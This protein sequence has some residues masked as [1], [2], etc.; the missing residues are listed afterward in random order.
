MTCIVIIHGPH[1]VYLR[2][3]TIIWRVCVC[4]M[5]ML[6]RRD[7]GDFGHF[8]WLS[9]NIN[10]VISQIYHQLNCLY[11][12]ANFLAE[13]DMSL[14]V[15]LSVPVKTI[16]VPL[17]FWGWL[18]IARETRSDTAR[19]TSNTVRETSDTKGYIGHGLGDLGHQRRLRA[20]T[21]T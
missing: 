10:Y 14:K 15:V 8:F 1:S 3:L 4:R 11:S 2:A 12:I 7:W 20:P 13:K 17:D 19:E 21:E 16:H 9:T 5:P 6:G 18:R